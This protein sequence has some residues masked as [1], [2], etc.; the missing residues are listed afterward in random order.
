METQMTIEPL[1][2]ASPSVCLG[3]AMFRSIPLDALGRA[4]IKAADKLGRPF[5]RTVLCQLPAA[6]KTEPMG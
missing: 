1:S 3:E 5:A 4:V 6:A 2:K